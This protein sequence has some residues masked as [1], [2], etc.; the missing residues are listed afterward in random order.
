[1]SLKIKPI[2]GHHS[3]AREAFHKEK[4]LKTT[5][6]AKCHPPTEFLPLDPVGALPPS[7]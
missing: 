5:V 3:S 4:W 6:T 1:M 7:R 2:V